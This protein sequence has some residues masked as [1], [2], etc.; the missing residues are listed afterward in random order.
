MRA[1]PIVRSRISDSNI[2]EHPLA[3]RK[4]DKS[5]RLIVVPHRVGSI[6]SS[7]GIIC[8]LRLRLR[9]SRVYQFRY[10]TPILAFAIF[11]FFQ[12]VYSLVLFL[13]PASLV[14]Y[15]YR[16]T[17]SVFR[18]RS[19]NRAR[20]IAAHLLFISLPLSLCLPFDHY[21]EKQ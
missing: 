17:P 7:V 13:H 11:F 21:A 14:R 4:S 12:H 6:L 15:S 19:I 8:G 9:S 18:Y 5:K 3:R 20:T 10:R 2:Y 1:F 16:K